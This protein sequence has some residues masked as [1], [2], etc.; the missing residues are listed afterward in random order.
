MPTDDE[1]Q[2]ETI[3]SHLFP[4]LASERPDAE[5]I[6]RGLSP[7]RTDLCDL[8]KEGVRDALST[9][10]RQTN[11]S[12]Q[13]GLPRPQLISPPAMRPL[14]VP[15]QYPREASAVEPC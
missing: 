5:R 8:Q 4:L 3:R 10:R 14:R 2:Y 7:D 1:M 13:D 6:R 9:L 11:R 15:L 12:A